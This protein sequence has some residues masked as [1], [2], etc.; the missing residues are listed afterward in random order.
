MNEAIRTKMLI[1]V[2]TLTNK[3]GLVLVINMAIALGLG[4]PGIAGVE[5]RLRPL[6]IEYPDRKCNPWVWGFSRRQTTGA[7]SQIS[8]NAINRYIKAIRKPIKSGKDCKIREEIIAVGK[9]IV[10]YLIPLLQSA[11]KRMVTDVLDILMG[12]QVIPI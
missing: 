5:F 3:A 7:Q 11:D 9:P 12:M 1:T 2:M 6:P 10:P 4:Q 8:T